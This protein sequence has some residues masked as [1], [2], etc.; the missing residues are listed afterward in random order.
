MVDN[1]IGTASVFRVARELAVVH[2]DL[3]QGMPQ[4]LG[5]SGVDLVTISQKKQL[6]F[7]KSD[8]Q[9][10]VLWV[11]LIRHTLIDGLHHITEHIPLGALDTLHGE[12]ISQHFQV[13]VLCDSAKNVPVKYV[14]VLPVAP[15]AV[16][17][18]G[19]ELD[20]RVGVLWL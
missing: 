4:S 8:V 6:L 1:V 3:L 7:S 2:H 19:L 10:V 5:C 9:L 18:R 11:Q 20:V 16:K 12:P 13:L 17:R 15:A 14:Q